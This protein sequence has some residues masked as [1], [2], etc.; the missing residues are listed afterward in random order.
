MSFPIQT[1]EEMEYDIIVMDNFI[2]FMLY[3]DVQWKI[4][5]WKCKI[6]TVKQIGSSSSDAENNICS[7]TKN[8]RVWR[9]IMAD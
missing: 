6:I 9:R 8:G 3:M 1:L 7:S 2:V 4:Q 5:A